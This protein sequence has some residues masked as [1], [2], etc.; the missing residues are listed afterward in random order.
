MLLILLRTNAHTML[1]D[2][3]DY[4]WRNPWGQAPQGIETQGFLG[5]AKP[6]LGY[7]YAY[8]TPAGCHCNVVQ[9][10]GF[11]SRRASKRSLSQRIFNRVGKRCSSWRLPRLQLVEALITQGSKHPPLSSLGRKSREGTKIISS[12]LI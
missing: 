10:L 1:H 7:F 4:Y 3:S 5:W 12:N 2:S 11:P 8:K 9:H 6:K